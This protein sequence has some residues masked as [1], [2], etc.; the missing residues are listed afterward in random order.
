M[1]EFERLTGGKEEELLRSGWENIGGNRHGQFN[2]R[3]FSVKSETKNVSW[4][5]LRSKII[6]VSS[7]SPFPYFF[8]SPV[9]RSDT[10]RIS[11][12]SRTYPSCNGIKKKW[13]SFAWYS[14]YRY[15]TCIRIGYRYDGICLLTSQMLVECCLCKIRT[16]TFTQAYVHLHTLSSIFLNMMK[17]KSSVGSLVQSGALDDLVGPA[18]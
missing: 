5:V 15:P 17:P 16:D 7:F 9:S 6:K 13:F 4:V 3:S 12:L 2:L 18:S 14:M 8:S 11:A 10:R 1:S